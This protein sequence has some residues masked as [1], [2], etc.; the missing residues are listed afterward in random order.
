LA[1]LYGEQGQ[2]EKMFSNYIDVLGSNPNLLPGVSR[3]Y[4]Q[5]I[6]DDPAN[7]ANVIFRRLLLKRLQEDQ[8]ILYNEMLSWLFVQQKEFQKAFQQEKAIYRRGQQ[9]LGS[10]LRLTVMAREEGQSE[11][12]LELLDF[13]IAE[14]ASEELKL[15]AHQLR[16]NVLQEILP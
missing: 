8:N 15:Q 3:I 4:G 11:T 16:L 13:V 5:F 14:T 6:T 2:I 9:G 10:I 7:E 1:R 12:A